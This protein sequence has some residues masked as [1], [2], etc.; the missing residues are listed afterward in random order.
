M[1]AKIIWIVIQA[2]TAI[3]IP[4]FPIKIIFATSIS[5]E[6]ASIIPVKDGTKVVLNMNCYNIHDT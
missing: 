1:K 3:Y 4:S 5:L 6:K 2:K